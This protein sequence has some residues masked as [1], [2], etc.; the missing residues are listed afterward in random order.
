MNHCLY[1]QAALAL[2]GVDLPR[3]TPRI[4]FRANFDSGVCTIRSASMLLRVA[5]DFLRPLFGG[6]EN[7]SARCGWR[8]ISYRLK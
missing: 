1:V 7:R 6:E 8:A 4:A 3:L 2:L 5:L